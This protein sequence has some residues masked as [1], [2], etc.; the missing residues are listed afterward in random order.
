MADDSHKPPRAGS[1]SDADRALGSKR[2]RT[3][4]RVAGIP[5]ILGEEDS[6]PIIVD[7]GDDPTPVEMP[8]GRKRRQRV[9]IQ[10]FAEDCK[11]EIRELRKSHAEL[12]LAEFNVRAEITERIVKL[13]AQ[14]EFL[15]GLGKST[16]ELRQL[17]ID[18][19]E[20]RT[21]LIGADGTNGKISTLTKAAERGPRFIRRSIA[22]ALGGIL[23]SV[24]P[25]ALYVRNIVEASATER[26]TV[27]SQLEAAQ[28]DRGVIHAEVLLLFR[29]VNFNG[30][31]D[32][33]DAGAP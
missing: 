14:L 29:L 13:E 15:D 16:D 27:R 6:L 20:L 10:Q 5:D 9:T 33:P 3:A 7:A 12:V 26:A 22:L 11:L 32:R 28:V 8:A 4:D 21:T 25:A 18:L 24:I 17:R 23:G 2:Q 19:T 31:G 30:S 1:M